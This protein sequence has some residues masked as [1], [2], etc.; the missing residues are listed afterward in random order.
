ML[1]FLRRLFRLPPNALRRYLP[2]LALFV[3]CATLIPYADATNYVGTRPIT[4]GGGAP[5]G[6]AGGDLGG[7]YPN[8]TVKGLQGNGVAAT[9]P[10]S[11]NN[12]VW[13]GSNWA[14]AAVNLAGGSQYVSG[15][16]PIANV[17][18]CSAGQFLETN[19]GATA[20][21]C[22]TL[23]NDCAVGATG[24]VSCSKASGATSDYPVVVN[25]VTVSDDNAWSGTVGSPAQERVLKRYHFVLNTSA[26]GSTQAFTFP[27]PTSNT[28][29]MAFIWGSFWE[30]GGVGFGGG[31]WG[32]G[33]QNNAGTLASTACSGGQFLSGSLPI[34]AITPSVS[35]TNAIIS[36]TLATATAIKW[37]FT[38]DVIRN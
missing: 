24:S 31:A 8:P 5:S 10:N 36:I 38:V 13:N 37:T 17:G 1:E 4:G 16:L 33:F 22:V 19:A 9:T 6:S 3:A 23:S 30:T 15:L 21:S 11:G 35:G 2:G 20:Q 26:T 7:T 18:V 27:V 12:L 29:A 28:S 14:P 34:S 32:C 25:S